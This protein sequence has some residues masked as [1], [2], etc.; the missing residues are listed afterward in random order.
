MKFSIENVAQAGG[1]G[2]K[3]VRRQITCTIGD[4]EYTYDVN[5]RRLS[6]FEAV[7]SVEDLDPG[8]I[9]AQ[10]IAACIVDDDGRPVMRAEDVTGIK[11]DGEPVLDERG[12][13]RGGLLPELIVAL[14]NV[15]SEVNGLGKLPTSAEPTSSGTS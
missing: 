10:R 7:E 4:Q 8:V 14:G 13:P 1:F 2:G 15:L 5:V 12:K 11:E 9:L 3:V 6:Y